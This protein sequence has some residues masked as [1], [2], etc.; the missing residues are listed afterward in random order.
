[1]ERRN[2][3]LELH[4]TG[5]AHAQGPLD[6]CRAFVDLAPVPAGAV[7]VLERDEVAVGIGARFATS[8]VQQ[9]QRQQ[10]PR[11]RL[12]GHELDEQAGEVDRFG[13][14]VAADEGI[15]AAGGVALVE[16]EVDHAEHARESLGQAMIGRHLVG[17][18]SV[19]ELAPCA[20]EPF[21]Q[22][23]L[24]HQKS[25]G[26]LRRGDPG[27]GVKRERDL[28]LGCQ[29]RVTAGENEPEAIVLEEGFSVQ[30]SWHVG[31]VLTLGNGSLRLQKGV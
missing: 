10:A 3:R 30:Q 29:S 5:P 20:H 22:G 9:H 11:F 13:T 12:I 18:A 8:V 23:G 16:N 17:N 24:G 15:A 27:Y 1:M 2:R 28:C 4:G 31:G 14:E 21:G 7:L 25:A 6:H 26:N 19:A